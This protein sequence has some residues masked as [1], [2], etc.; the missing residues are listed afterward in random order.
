MKISRTESHAK[1]TK[2]VA[3]AVIPAKTP[4]S[5]GVNGFT[6]WLGTGSLHGFSRTALA[7]GAIGSATK[8]ED[9]YVEVYMV[10]ATTP[11]VVGDVVAFT[12][13]GGNYTI[14]NGTGA[15]VTGIRAYMPQKDI[16]VVPTIAGHFIEIGFYG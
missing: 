3:A 9:A 15:Y 1:P 11:Y 7:L 6:V 5:L 13:S 10:G 14:A 4:V 12:Y 16:G 2:A 8:K